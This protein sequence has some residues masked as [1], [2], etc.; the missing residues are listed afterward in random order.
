MIRVIRC[1]RHLGRVVAVIPVEF[2]IATSIGCAGVKSVFHLLAFISI[3]AIVVYACVA[4]RDEVHVVDAWDGSVRQAVPAMLADEAPDP[5]GSEPV[6]RRCACAF[7][8]DLRPLS[9]SGRAI[10][11]EQRMGAARSS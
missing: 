9:S 4:F 2:P 10:R 5:V 8:S 3:C 7:E 6:V 1:V 11:G